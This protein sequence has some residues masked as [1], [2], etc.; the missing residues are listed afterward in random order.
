VRRDW[1]TRVTRLFHMCDMTH[2]SSVLFNCWSCWSHMCDTTH[3]RVT[4][5]IHM[6]N[7]TDSHVWREWFTCVTWHIPPVP[8]S[9]VA[10]AQRPWL[11]RWPCWLLDPPVSHVTHVNGS[12]HT[13]EWVMSH[14]WMSHVTHVNTSC[15]TCQPLTS[16]MTLLI[17]WSACDS[18]HTCE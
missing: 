17:T 15:H 12:C 13:C 2:T 5:L 8:F 7:M 16:T 6:R 3:S 1:F 9:T 18:S 14:M 4:R 11:L 10:R